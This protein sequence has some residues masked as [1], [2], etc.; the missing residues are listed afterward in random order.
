MKG[1][2]EGSARARPAMLPASRGKRPSEFRQIVS[3]GPRGNEGTN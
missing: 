2:M 3:A 1:R